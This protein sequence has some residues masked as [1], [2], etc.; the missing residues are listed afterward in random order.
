MWHIVSRAVIKHSV[1]L[2]NVV[3]VKKM[4]FKK[5]VNKYRCKHCGKTFKRKSKKIWVKSYCTAMEKYVH[6]IK[7]ESL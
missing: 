1:H 6:L 5:F 2:S 3:K 7:I 4:G